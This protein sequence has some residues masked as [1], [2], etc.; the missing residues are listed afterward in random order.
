MNIE[1][2]GKY[3]SITSFTWNDIPNFVV[4]T[5]QNGTGKSQLLELIYST[6]ISTTGM[7]PRVTIEGKSFKRDEVTFLKGE[8]D[9]QGTGDVDLASIQQQL[10]SFYSQFLSQQ[11][12]AH[13]VDNRRLFQIFEDIHRKSGKTIRGDISLNEFRQF[14]PDILIGHERRMSHEISEIF[15][16]YR[17]SEISLLA[18]HKTEDEIKAEI[19]EKPWVVLRDI[20]KESKLPFEF[21]SPENMDIMDKFHFVLTHS[22]LNEPINFYD[23]S[24]GE[25][26]LISLVFYLYSSQEKHAFPK[27]LLL[28]EPD[29][30]LHPSMSQQF[31]DVI[32]NVLVDKYGVQVIMTTHS[33]STVILAPDE[34]I[35]EM[36]I[37]E[38][39][40]KKG[41]SKNHCVSLLTGGLIFVGEGAKYILVEDT[42]DRDFYNHIYSQ[43]TAENFISSDIPLVF[44]P[45]S[46]KDKSGGSLVVQDWVKKLRDSGLVGIL[47][48]LI[49]ADS[50]NDV[51]DG[52]YKIDR[53]SIENYLADPILVYAVLIDIEKAPTIE[54]INLSV[55][56][57]YKLK[58]LPEESL[59]KIS[60]KIF[61]IVETELKVVFTDFDETND[62]KKIEIKYTNGTKLL[63]PQW[64]IKRQG[65]TIIHQ[66][67]NKVFSS[68]INSTSLFKALRKLNMFPTDFVEKFTEIKNG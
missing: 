41:T 22:V 61:E 15:Y 5:G 11:I 59:Q 65:K 9:I 27:L 52:I 46:T 12:Q 45:A 57:E 31:L 3:K 23:L 19:G 6:I 62:R 43:L 44:V 50:G 20:I 66:L 8:W 55:G 16:K 51:S 14:F 10:N 29:A 21:S 33:P 64:M 7:P 18:K 2:T 38:P 67:Y 28:D 56:E 1:F 37:T 36:S 26:V 32:K 63:F 54:G 40:I 17:L 34:S 25:K 68:L 39:R 48:G 13:D 24:S 42:A 53:Y 60:D 4:I 47:R 49:D 35:Y 30:H 58:I